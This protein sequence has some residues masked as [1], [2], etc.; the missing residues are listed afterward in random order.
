MNGKK[1]HQRAFQR[2]AGWCEAESGM[3][4]LA[5]EQFVEIPTG[6]LVRVK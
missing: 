1:R 2:S 3:A 6:K 4:T 5:R